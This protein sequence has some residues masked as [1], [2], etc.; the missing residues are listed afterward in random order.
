MEPEKKSSH[1]SIGVIIGAIA[2]LGIAAFG[3]SP[4]KDL[5]AAAPLQPEQ[6]TTVPVASEPSVPPVKTTPQVLAAMYKNGTYTAAGSYMS[7]GGLDDLSVSLTLKDDIVTDVSMTPGAHDRRS[8]QYQAKFM[9]G[10][11]EYVVGKNIADIN[12]TKV[13][14]A[15]LTPKGFNDALA[16]IKAQAKA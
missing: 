15:S 9:S 4:K 1:K 13:S 5:P 3:L 14:G 16:K 8:E 12:L 6:P 2:V 10:Y 11:K 7:P